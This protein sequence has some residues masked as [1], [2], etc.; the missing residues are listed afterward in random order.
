MSGLPIL[1]SLLA[2]SCLLCCSNGLIAQQA[3]PLEA[4]PI[5]RNLSAEQEA[6]AQRWLHGLT[7]RQKIAQLLVISFYG[8]FPEIGSEEE[9]RLRKLVEEDGVGG[10]IVL[11]RVF[12]GAVR[13]AHPYEMAAFLNRMQS[14]AAVP[15]LVAGDFERGPSM[16]LDG[17]TLF[18]HAMA[19]G[20]A[21]DP[22]LTRRFGEI[23]A[24]ESRALGVH[25]ILAPSAD[26]NSDP[27]NPVIH[28]RSFGETASGVSRHVAAFVRG[29]QE[30]AACPLLATAKH[31]P[32][33]GDTSV[34]SHYGVP[35]IQRS[36]ETL[37]AVDIPPF[38][39]AID[40]GVAS[41][42]PGHLSV[43]AL[44]ESG[45]SAT[46]SKP[47]VTGY[48]RDRLHFGGIITTDGLD[49]AGLTKLYEPGEASVRALEAGADV[50]MIPPNPNAAINAVEAAVASGRLSEARIDESVRRVL[51]AK[52]RLDL[53]RKKQVKIEDIAT[54]ASSA[55]GNALALEVARKAIT[56]LRNHHHV[57]PLSAEASPC[58][59]VLNR[60]RFSNDG[61]AFARTFRRI[62][63]K[64][65]AWF[66]DETWSAA[67]MAQLSRDL[68][69]CQSVSVASFVSIAGFAAGEI[70]L[71]R[72]QADLVKSVERSSENLVLVGFTNPYLAS[73]FPNASAAV[74][75]FSN[76]PT[77]EQAAA[78]AIFGLFPMTGR[79]PVTIPGLTEAALEG[80]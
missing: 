24:C 29:V 4:P 42:M 79:S 10:M 41:V 2:I 3:P 11:N 34:D 64:S 62:A 57:L 40:A 12:E 8:Y 47:I 77:S 80:F 35:V 1:R 56:L 45:D 46:V 22:E 52:A 19:F 53:F 6:Q 55:S 51:R 39:A 16:R 72:P 18:P 76:V 44:D 13:R 17:M 25:W 31:F 74:V 63:P 26:V 9:L 70:P 75:P 32:G 38:K 48:L 65:R 20:A 68:T 37:E 78:E 27:G 67:A 30:N 23:T 36:R 61:R 69:S 15:L 58:A 21:G 66:V 71:P 60:G 49:M 5:L 7:L 43:P 14:F 73:Y 54:V 50:L 33:H 59:V 28:L